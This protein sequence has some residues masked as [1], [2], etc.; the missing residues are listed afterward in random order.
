MYIRA[1]RRGFWICL[2]IP[3]EKKAQKA[4]SIWTNFFFDFNLAYLEN[5]FSQN[6][7]I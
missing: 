5:K 6:P 1:L 2:L 4:K 7:P 3:P